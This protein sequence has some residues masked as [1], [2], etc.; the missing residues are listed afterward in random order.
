MCECRLEQRAF[1]RIAGPD[2]SERC[3]QADALDIVFF[4][5]HTF[6]ENS[7]AVLY[8]DMF[9]R[10]RII[11]QGCFS[12]VDRL[13]VFRPTERRHGHCTGTGVK[14]I[15]GNHSAILVP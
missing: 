10:L 5:K 14:C 8:D 4:D 11:V 13:L 12:E 9:Y 15:E 7:D 1:F 6:A 3:R 2:A